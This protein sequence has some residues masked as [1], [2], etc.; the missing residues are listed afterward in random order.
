MIDEDGLFSLVAAAPAPQGMDVDEAAAPEDSWDAV[1]ER[2]C[3]CIS[4]AVLLHFT[5]HGGGCGGARGLGMRRAC[6]VALVWLL[7]LRCCAAAL[8]LCRHGAGRGCRRPAQLCGLGFGARH[9]ALA[10]T[11][12]PAPA[13]AAGGDGSGRRRG[14]AAAAAGRG[15]AGCQ[16]GA[17]GGGRCPAQPQRHRGPQ[18]LRQRRRRPPAGGGGGRRGGGARA[19]APCGQPAALGGEVAA[20][21]VPGAHWQQRAAGARLPGC[22]GAAGPACERGSGRGRWMPVQTHGRE[23]APV[24][25][26]APLPTPRVQSLVA[27]L[28]HWLGSWEQVH[29]HNKPPSVPQS[30]RWG[31]GRHA[32]WGHAGSWPCCGLPARPRRGELQARRLCFGCSLG[33]AAGWDAQ[34]AAEAAAAAA[35]Q[36]AGGLKH[37][38]CAMW[39]CNTC[40]PLS[41][42]KGAHEAG[43]PEEEGGAAERPPRHRQDQ[44]RPHRLPRAGL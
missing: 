31:L 20:P 41:A 38:P 5:W 35:L 13:S 4:T 29:L 16:A 30:Y 15:A 18:L 10:V 33:A 7:R 21:N 17:G 6:A 39:L 19:A 25:M 8:R 22:A 32:G 11:A 12:S 36:P 34:A 42:V 28:K 26:R 23:V 24:Q 27:L 1:R 37:S 2:L 40:L 3:C 9:G 14:A 43:G 44:L